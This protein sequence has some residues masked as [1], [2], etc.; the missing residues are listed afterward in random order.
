MTF[1][2][3]WLGSA[4]ERGR[5]QRRLVAKGSTDHRS[6]AWRT[7]L[8]RARTTPRRGRPTA[9]GPPPQAA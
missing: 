7:E 1:G 8:A 5:A 2:S 4:R 6:K 9:S 3:R